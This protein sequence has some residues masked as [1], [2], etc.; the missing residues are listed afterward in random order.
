MPSKKGLGGPVANARKRSA[1]KQARGALTATAV[2]VRVRQ[3]KW[4]RH[5]GHL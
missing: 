1:E 2:H 4:R 3:Q 5:A